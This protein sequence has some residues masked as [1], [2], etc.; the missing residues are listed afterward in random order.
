MGQQGLRLTT[1]TQKAGR[2]VNDKVARILLKYRK[3]IIEEWAHRL[4]TEISPYS[5]RPL[6]ELLR[7]ISQVTDANSVAISNNDFS[8]IDSF[9]EWIGK[10][11]SQTVFL[12]SNQDVSG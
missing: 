6:D 2:V 1:H 3:A 11:W 5:A 7:T 12:P 10:T 8:R 9:I 4:H